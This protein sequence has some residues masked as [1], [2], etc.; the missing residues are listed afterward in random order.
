M[1]LVVH[2]MC[3]FLGPPS[4]HLSP[5]LQADETKS[6]HIKVIDYTSD[7]PLLYGAFSSPTG[8]VNVMI[9]KSGY[10]FEAEATVYSLI[11]RPEVSNNDKILH[12]FHSSSDSREPYFVLEHYGEDLRS[13][14]EADLAVRTG[15][16]LEGIISAL[17]FLHHH[18]RYVHGDLQPSSIRISEWRG[19]FSC[20]LCHFHNACRV[21]EPLPQDNGELLITETWTCPELFWA[22]REKKSISGTF[23][24]DIFNLGLIIDRLCD[25]DHLQSKSVIDVS[26]VTR[27]RLFLSANES[28][29]MESTYCVRNN[30]WL[31]DVLRSMLSFEPHQRKDIEVYRESLAKRSTSYFYHELCLREKISLGKQEK[32]E[33]QLEQ[34][35]CVLHNVRQLVSTN[36]VQMRAELTNH[37]TTLQ[38]NLR[39]HSSHELK[40]HVDS[41]VKRL[42]IE[43]EAAGKS[44]LG[45][46]QAT[47]S[48]QMNEVS[49]E[50]AKKLDTNSSEI[51]AQLTTIKNE[52]HCENNQLKVFSEELKLLN[53]KSNTLA[54]KVDSFGN[55]ALESFDG[56]KA[57]IES[58]ASTEEL[59]T[60]CQQFK[61]NFDEKALQLT[62]DVGRLIDQNDQISPI[63]E[64]IQVSVSDKQD[65]R[66][67][68]ANQA[69]VK[70]LIEELSKILVSQVVV[71]NQKI[72]SAY[73][74]IDNI[75]RQLPP[76]SMDTVLSDRLSSIEALLAAA[77]TATQSNDLLSEVRNLTTEFHLHDQEM[78]QIIGT[79]VDDIQSVRNFQDL[80]I[81]D[82]QRYPFLF[83]IWEEKLKES[84][85]NGPFGALIHGARETVYRH[86]R[87]HFCCNVCGKVAQSGSKAQRTDRGLLQRTR[88]SLSL[89]D[90]GQGG[91]PLS[92]MRRSVVKFLRYA[93]IIV[94]ALELGAKLG[95]VSLSSLVSTVSR[96]LNIADEMRKLAESLEDEKF[97]PRVIQNQ[98]ENVLSPDQ[99]HDRD[100]S[101]GKGHRG[102]MAMSLGAAGGSDNDEK[103]R[104]VKEKGV[105]G[106]KKTRAE[107]G[108]EWRAQRPHITVEHAKMAKELL[109]LLKDP[110]GE[111]TGLQRCTRDDGTCAWVCPEDES[112]PHCCFKRFKAEGYECCL[113]G[114]AHFLTKNDK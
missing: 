5:L 100:H 25:P 28:E 93:R 74:S 59:Q 11:R 69:E 48:G 75:I 72:E 15:P 38:N 51:S 10:N 90:H 68:E 4:S 22:A 111:D 108:N 45:S 78:K 32:I 114:L 94:A 42:T 35:S 85:L 17:Q 102:G 23:H 104:T 87:V 41:M 107:L 64:A 62:R 12:C 3:V 73:A 37:L 16:L 96:E 9:K 60:F 61:L 50:I 89:V 31:G 67:L 21:G 43:N 77:A 79:V 6:I 40:Q 14:Y 84:V 112:N 80:S 76:A 106:H 81:D 39:E 2:S 65:Q 46:I 58:A 57:L 26:S 101:P 24:M 83:I 20:K 99:N 27:E 92:V 88:E 91:Y 30:H 34:M 44:L 18:L 19:R 53:L 82:A 56:L 29:F 7:S 47:V 55:L 110:T 71:A 103:L 54:D 109:H 49:I 13:Y 8:N 105:E 66:Q 52:I 95:G 98:V 97:L 36:F 113:A 63:L 1:R 70:R 86:Y 33:A